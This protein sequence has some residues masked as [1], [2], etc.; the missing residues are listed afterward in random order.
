VS[1]E[2]LEVA[3]HAVDAPVGPAVVLHLVM[4]LRVEHVLRLPAEH[5]QGDEE[6]LVRPGRAVAV[7]L[8][9]EEEEGSLDLRGDP[10][11]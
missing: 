1:V 8:G 11:R 9:L 6:L 10:Q 4:L 3:L 2:P 5:L 7:L